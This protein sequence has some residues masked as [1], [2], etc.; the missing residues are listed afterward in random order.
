MKYDRTWIQWIPDYSWVYSASCSNRYTHFPSHLLYIDFVIFVV[1]S[2]RLAFIITILHSMRWGK[3]KSKPKPRSIPFK[4]WIGLCLCLCQ[5]PTHTWFVRN[6][7]WIQFFHWFLLFYRVL[8]A[9]IYVLSNEEAAIKAKDKT[10]FSEL[11]TGN[12]CDVAI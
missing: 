9:R 3:T 4:V 1:R 5:K 7:Q 10:I 8:R 11:V 12:R 6:L 2:M